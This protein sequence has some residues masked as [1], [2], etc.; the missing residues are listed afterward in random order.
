[1][2]LRFSTVHAS[3]SAGALRV[4][5]GRFDMV[6][7]GITMSGFSPPRT[8]PRMAFS[9]PPSL[10][11]T[12]ARTY[13]LPAGHD[14][15]VRTNVHGPASDTS[16]LVPLGYADGVPRA[17][18]NGGKMLVRGQRVPIIGRVSMDQ[19]V[20]DLSSV[21][22]AREGDVVIALGPDGAD[23]LTL[24]EFARAADTIPHEALC[25]LGPRLPR[26]YRRG[27]EVSRVMI[28]EGSDPFP[29][30]SHA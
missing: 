12:L 24:H 3:N 28:F 5:K 4:P 20:V 30:K 21:P 29:P 14:Y 16:G 23:E 17:L 15:R 11:A 10:K 8:C 7:T 6:R 1:M 27:G 22:D 2:G 25:R 9:L 18:S 19:C 26:V 13:N